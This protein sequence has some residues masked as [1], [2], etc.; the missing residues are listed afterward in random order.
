MIEIDNKVKLLYED[1][2]LIVAIKPSGILSQED[3]T[4]D[5]DMLN[6]IKKY[7]VSKYNKKGDAFLGLLH[8]LDRPVSGVMIFAKTSKCASRISEQI[9]NKEVQ[10]KYLAIVHG[11]PIKLEGELS[12]YIKKDKV[13]NI[14]EYTKNPIDPENYKKAVLEYKT[15]KSIEN[16]SLIE[17]NLITGR[18]HQ[19]RLQLSDINIPIFGDRKYSSYKDNSQ[20]ALFAYKIRIA[21][22]ITKEF[23]E[24]VG[25]PPNEYP[26]N[27]F[28]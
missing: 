21:H 28:N 10:K 26:W 2:H 23:I 12:G 19:I 16:L 9:R 15:I 14:S 1:N 27:L 13:T 18:S 17:I 6:I 8:R 11:K 5:P 25:E 24:F 22:P 3:S 20:I 4:K 7:L